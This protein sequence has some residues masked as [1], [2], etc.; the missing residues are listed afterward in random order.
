MEDLNYG[1]IRIKL[2]E[3]IEKQESVRINWAITEQRCERTQ[4]N[5]FCKRNCDKIG[6]SCFGAAVLCAGL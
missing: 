3:M 5:Q 6:Y 2:D 1:S 4:L